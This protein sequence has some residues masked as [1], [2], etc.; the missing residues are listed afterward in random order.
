MTAGSG[1]FPPGFRVV[2]DADVRRF[3]EDQVMLGGS[4]MRLV[5]LSR[6]G[7]AVLGSLTHGG[8]IPEDPEGQRLVRRL[9]QIGMLHPRPAGRAMTAAD[10]TVVVPVRD[11]PQ[12][13]ARL[14]E[15]FTSQGLGGV[16]VVDD[17][18]CPAVCCHR[19]VATA[20][21]H[22]SGSGTAA[23]TVRSE[24]PGGPAAA[25]MT[26]I[27]RAPTALVAFVDADVLTTPGWLDALLVHFDDPEVAATAP[28]VL[29]SKARG[30]ALARYEQHRSPLDLGSRE[31]R[32]HPRGTVPYV[33]TAAIV[34][35]RTALDAIGGF[36]ESLQVGEDVDLV[37]RLD[38]AGLTVRYVPG[39]IVHHDVRP[40]VASWV[41]Q[42][43]RY[44]TSAAP[45]DA[46]HRG[47]LAP[48]VMSGWSLS[49]WV[50]AGLG[51]PRTAAGLAGITTAALVPQLR[52]LPR[53]EREALRLAGRGHLRAGGFAADAV[54]RSWW[55][56]AVVVAIA[57][58]RVRRAV[59]A[60]F[61]VPPLWQWATRQPRGIDPVRWSALWWA[62][63]LAYGAGVWVGCLRHHRL[64]PLVP[65]LVGW[66][67]KH[68]RRRLPSSRTG[69][70]RST[71]VDTLDQPGG[72]R[73]T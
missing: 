21:G 9:L 48:L 5:R 55:P 61:V 4:P 11:Q 60:A 39:S 2:V 28:R 46:R 71:R 64:G 10:V 18:S 29:A 56:A 19:D 15:G 34:V 42:R 13:L 59:I 27:G 62:D 23:E 41:K 53:P 44:G 65:D 7:A 30:G 69:K 43:Y 37:W 33:P 20:L 26:G 54:R 72:S 50:L 57:S 68:P 40:G 3:H 58:R 35:R 36:D 24:R 1:S 38:E 67:P 47:A 51:M 6:T 8:S 25:R 70:V 49:V 63:D 22:L 45:L 16:V 14:L 73:L 66:S 17:G 31:A 52:A 32:V 12:Q